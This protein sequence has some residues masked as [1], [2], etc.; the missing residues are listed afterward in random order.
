MHF[1][2]AVLL[3]FMG[4]FQQIPVSAIGPLVPYEMNQR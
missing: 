1:G 2:H 4:M 3:F